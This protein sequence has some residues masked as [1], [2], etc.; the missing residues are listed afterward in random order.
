[1]RDL[2][3][4]ICVCLLRYLP[5]QSK[6]LWVC[7]LHRW[8]AHSPLKDQL[9]CELS[10]AGWL[11]TVDEKAFKKIDQRAKKVHKKYRQWPQCTALTGLTFDFTS[12]LCN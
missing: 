2:W 12:A 1:M 8:A 5:T 6:G 9:N 11:K 4:H 10:N 7:N 3:Y